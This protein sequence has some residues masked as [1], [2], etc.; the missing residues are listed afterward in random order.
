MYNDSMNKYNQF[1][2]QRV[3]LSRRQFLGLIGV[4]GVG[5][6]GLCG[7][8]TAG[9][10]SLLRPDPIPTAT[11]PPTIIPSTPRLIVE[12]PDIIERANWRAIPPD[13]NA[14]N[15]RGYYDKLTN[16]QGWYV[17]PD[18]LEN[19]YQTLVIH[20]SGFYWGTGQATLNEIIRLHVQDRQWADVAYHFLIDKDG[21]IYEGRDISVRGAHVGGFN[22]GSVGVCLLGDFRLEAPSQVQLNS[23]YALNDWLVFRLQLTHLAGHQQFNDWTACPGKFITESIRGY[24]KS[25]WFGVWHRWLYSVGTGA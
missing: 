20:H 7:G 4:F 8:V 6:G 11:T 17:Y 21:T 18:F 10:L 25:C 23:T 5:A 15:E 1:L 12:K 14:R 19:S 2:N 13:H 16:P 22:T 24:G 3:Q 9:G